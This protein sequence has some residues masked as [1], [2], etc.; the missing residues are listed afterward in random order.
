MIVL[1]ESVVCF[2]LVDTLP[3]GKGMVD[4]GGRGQ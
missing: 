2:V 3:K 1:T 4:G